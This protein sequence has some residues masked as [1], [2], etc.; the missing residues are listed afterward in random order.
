MFASISMLGASPGEKLW[1]LLPEPVQLGM[2]AMLMLERT[3]AALVFMIS[4][5][6]LGRVTVMLWRVRV[7]VAATVVTTVLLRKYAHDSRLPKEDK[8]CST[9]FQ[10]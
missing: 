7:I 6:G 9:S 10:L 8:E 1:R 2:L 4:S 5:L 3:F